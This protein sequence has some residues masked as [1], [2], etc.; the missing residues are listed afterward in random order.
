MFNLFKK[1]N[2]LNESEISRLM[3]CGLSYNEAVRCA[4]RT[5][6]PTV[7]A[8]QPKPIEPTPEPE[9]QP[10]QPIKEPLSPRQKLILMLNEQ[11]YSQREISAM[12]EFALGTINLELSKIES[13]GYKIIRKPKVNQ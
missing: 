7:A 11:N 3:Y 5:P 2:P 12:T 8:E 10:V 4:S 6:A 13:K 9:P 1:R